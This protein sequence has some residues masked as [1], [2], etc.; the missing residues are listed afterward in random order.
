[1]CGRIIQDDQA[2][3]DS[4][5]SVSVCLWAR[6]GEGNSSQAWSQQSARVG[7]CSLSASRLMIRP[8][9]CWARWVTA[10]ARSAL[11]RKTTTWC[12][13]APTA[14]AVPPGATSMPLLN[15]QQ[16]ELRRPPAGL[17]SHEEGVRAALHWGGL[18]GVRVSVLTAC[19]TVKAF[20][21]LER[22][23]WKCGRHE[24]VPVP[25]CAQTSHPSGHNY[26]SATMGSQCI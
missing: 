6:C 8:A 23:R 13:A 20:S 5:A 17:R 2:M 25:L 14:T 16:H 3:L 26:D 7:R 18:Q 1:M 19:L 21:V 10:A 9:S 4:D 15:G 24:A 22:R 12:V 11:K